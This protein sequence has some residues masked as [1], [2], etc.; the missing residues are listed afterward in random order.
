MHKT[1]CP[2]RHRSGS[3]AIAR[4]PSGERTTEEQ[5]KDPAAAALRRKGG[6]ARAANTQKTTTSQRRKPRAF[7]AGRDGFWLGVGAVARGA[8]R[9]ISGGNSLFKDFLAGVDE[10]RHTSKIRDVNSTAQ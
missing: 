5:R 1:G 3:T 8:W 9:H 7:E 6:Q 2:F 4:A 10:I